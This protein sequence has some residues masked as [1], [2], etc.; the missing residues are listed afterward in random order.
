MRK[1]VIMICV[2]VL[3]CGVTEEMI[4]AEEDEALRYV[5]IGDEGTMGAISG[6]SFGVSYVDL[7]A[8]TLKQH[9][10]T[11]TISTDLLGK[12][13]TSEAL[14]HAIENENVESIEEADL[15]TLSIGRQDLLNYV[16]LN[17]QGQLVAFEP[18]MSEILKLRETI[19]AI[20]LE[21]K[22]ETS[23]NQVYVVGYA[24]IF[25]SVYAQEEESLD[26]FINQANRMLETVVH[27]QG[28]HFVPYSEVGEDPTHSYETIPT[29]H[30][31]DQVAKAF[32][33]Q[34]NLKKATTYSSVRADLLLENR[35]S[36]LFKKVG[37]D[38]TEEDKPVPYEEA[39]L[40]LGTFIP[41]MEETSLVTTSLDRSDPLYETVVGLKQLGIMEPFTPDQRKSN[42]QRGEFT[43]ILAQ[44]FG[45]GVKEVGDFKDV[46][47][48]DQRA[49]RINALEHIGIVEGYRD[50]T[51]QPD[52]FLSN[53]ELYRIV[54]RTYEVYFNEI[55]KR[56][57]SK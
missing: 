49:K 56:T 41:Q 32:T 51:F 18:S 6:R 44:I 35:V 2:L 19:E 11:V 39:L 26:E 43:M 21:I 28:F 38:I 46:Q 25:S 54:K 31:H 37:I 34:L 27:E 40:V 7:I 12:S 1:W 36:L 24:P 42:M 10:S 52:R 29:Q 14:L 3:V 30:W 53:R 33:N 5:A 9:H 55:E 23:S 13:Y 4:W 50:G 15:I 45:T 16:E 17:E 22:K 20:L 48:D 47:M 57:S 8:E